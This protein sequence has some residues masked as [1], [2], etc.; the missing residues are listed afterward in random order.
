MALSRRTLLASAGS[1]AMTAGLT[2]ACGTN[3]LD[4]L[5]VEAK[6]P[7]EG[8]VTVRWWAGKIPA[9]DGGDMRPAI[10]RA[11]RRKHPTI[12]VETVKGLST[13]DGN[14]VALT[15]QIGGGSTTPDVY[16][17]DTT[18]P[19]QFGANYLALP[20]DSLVP[21]SFWDP[22]PQALMQASSLKGKVYAFPCYTDAAYLFY[23]K[24]LL[25]KHGIP[26]PRTWEELERGARRIQ[27]AGD[28]D[29]GF[30]WQGSVSESLTCVVTEFLADAGGS[31]L[32]RSG[33]VA[34][35]DE[36][37]QR[38]V[39]Y[40]RGLVD[41]GVTPSAV[42][43]FAEQ[44]AMDAFAGGRAV[45]LR[46]WAYAWGMSE[47][48]GAS[49]VA[50]KVG[51]VPRPGFE[52]RPDSGYACLGGWS[53]FINPNSENLGAAVAF[54]RF[55]AGEE[56]Q[57]MLLREAGVLPAMDTVLDGPAAARTGDPTITTTRRLKL[58]ARPV[59]TPY[60]PQVSKAVYTQVN[61]AIGGSEPVGGALRAARS[62]IT[63]ALEGKAL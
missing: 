35:A 51:V 42:T 57:M 13:T 49:K 55:C 52:G 9:R 23:R 46:N 40:L 17:G 54:A 14:R 37:A 50:G 31:V 25:A 8:P 20:V 43:T 1:I 47:A 4:D 15:T 63:A 48:D 16:L 3:D 29:Y 34:V 12:R 24:D 56:A 5:L 36:P 19:A 7:P 45:F 44:D 62:D 28:A 53:N 32:D 41:A 33:R 58:V 26:V 27:R 2:T 61:S 22:Y 18:W 39:S 38:A 6:R 59:Q 60:Y 30:V 10:I 21:E 11:F